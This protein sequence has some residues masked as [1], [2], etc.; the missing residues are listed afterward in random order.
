MLKSVIRHGSTSQV[1]LQAIFDTSGLE[2]FDA[3]N[4]QRVLHIYH[5]P[6]YYIEYGLA[7]LGAIAMWRNYCQNPQSTIE[8]YKNALALGYTKDVPSIYQAAG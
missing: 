5:I 8:Q 7:Q 1:D 6:F 3:V 4:C 2:K